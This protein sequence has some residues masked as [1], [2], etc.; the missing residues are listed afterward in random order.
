MIEQ[1][2]RS[3]VYMEFLQAVVMVQEK[4]VKSAQEKVAHEVT[5]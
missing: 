4:E 3:S 1:K 2:V 5:L